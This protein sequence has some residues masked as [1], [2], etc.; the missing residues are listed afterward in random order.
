MLRPA[1]IC[2]VALASLSA[3]EYVW[4]GTEWK[5]QEPDSTGGAAPLPGAGGSSVSL[6]GGSSSEG[7]GNGNSW[8]DDYDDEDYDDNYTYDDD[9]EE[10]LKK[11]LKA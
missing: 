10:P 8:D 11:K 2:L 3:G 6:G 1:L 4:T 7:S 5:W 9:Y